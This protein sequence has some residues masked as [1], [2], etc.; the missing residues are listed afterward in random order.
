MSE[1]ASKTMV[2][3][4]LKDL[5][6]LPRLPFRQWGTAARRAHHRRGPPGAEACSGAARIAAGPRGLVDA[7]HGC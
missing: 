2:Y 5:L 3:R 6:S 7:P 1:N 4:F